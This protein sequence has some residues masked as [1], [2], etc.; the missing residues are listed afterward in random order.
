MSSRT[1]SGN[2]PK[3]VIRRRRRRKPAGVDLVASK[4]KDAEI[5][6]R[7]TS[8]TKN[9]V[10]T[11]AERRGTTVT[12]IITDFLENLIAEEVKKME[13]QF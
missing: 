7:V 13:K 1:G 2:P 8:A 3:R 6:I 4:V 11:I 9:G 10:H 5:N 12:K